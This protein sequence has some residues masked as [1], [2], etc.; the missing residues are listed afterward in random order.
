MAASAKYRSLW[1]EAMIPFPREAWT[2]AGL[3]PGSLPEGD[4]IP[5]EVEV[6]F[7]SLLK[8]EI[9][10]YDP[11]Q[12]TTE[13][14]KLDVLLI[15]VGAV[16]DNTDLLYVIDPKTDEVLQFDLVEQDIQGVN[17]NFRCF[18]E[19]LYHFERF[20]EADE[21]KPGRAGKAA[22]LQ[23]RLRAVDPNAFQPDAWWPLVLEQLTA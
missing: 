12:L 20:I 21:G 16:Q 11:I 7:T 19:F 9:G 5:M 8:G 3:P 1:G 17:T 2:D 10:M 4:E 22:E 14:G 18:V 6:V 15:V 13:N 23:E